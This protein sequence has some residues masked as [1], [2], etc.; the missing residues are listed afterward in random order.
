M[1]PR[2]MERRAYIMEV[3]LQARLATLDCLDTDQMSVREAYQSMLREIA[4]PVSEGFP[5]QEAADP[6]TMAPPTSVVDAAKQT[7]LDHAIAEPARVCLT[8]GVQLSEKPLNIQ[9]LTEQF[10]AARDC[11]EPLHRSPANALNA[12]RLDTVF[13]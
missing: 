10:D 9:R 6:E 4:K 3:Y 7:E 2:S 11:D 1:I 5:M 13:L 12:F 8:P